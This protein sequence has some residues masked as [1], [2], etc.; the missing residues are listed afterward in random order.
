[1]KL[2]TCPVVLYFFCKDRDNERDSF[3][4]IARSLL[5]QL[6]ALN[7][8]IL[9][10]YYHDRYV[11]S[12]EV[13]LSAQSIME[14]L[15]RT[16]IRNFPSVYII[17][18]GIDECPRKEREHIATWF[19]EL[20]EG[21]PA[22]NPDQVR[23]LFVSQDDGVARKDFAGVSTIKIKAEDNK[24]DIEKFGSKWAGKIQPKFDI[25]SE[26]RDEI[27]KC[28]VDAA[29]G[30]WCHFRFSFRAPRSPSDTIYYRHVSARKVDIDK[31]SSPSGCPWTEL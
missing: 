25:S 26:R 15:L 4:S 17:L 24:A 31:P 23:C 6:L 7:R 8:D 27:A 14:D 12:A 20:V 19:R 5:S 9:L 29:G 30:R 13:V 11:N 1:L 18:D 21:L 10:S 28:I 16:S 22:S 3:I 2:D